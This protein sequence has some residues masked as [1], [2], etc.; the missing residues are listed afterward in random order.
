MGVIPSAPSLVQ[1]IS[2]QLLNHG[3]EDWQGRHI[4]TEPRRDPPR[5][6]RPGRSKEEPFGIGQRENH[7]AGRNRTI[8]FDRVEFVEGSIANFVD[9]VIAGGDQPHGQQPQQRFLQQAQV[10]GRRFSVTA[11]TTPGRTYVSDCQM[12]G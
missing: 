5:E 7:I 8:T 1:A 9:D 6:Q 3:L 2:V 10:G 12:V 11:M 4:P